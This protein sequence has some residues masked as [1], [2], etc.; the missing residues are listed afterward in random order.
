MT[1]ARLHVLLALLAAQ[2]AAPAEA[3]EV[4][5]V[6]Q[7]RIAPRVVELTIATPAFTTP[8]KV[9]VDLPNGYDSAPRRRWPVAYV[10]AGTMNVR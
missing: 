4:R 2:V 5:I 1:R 9:H 7:E 3:N 10:L 6:K 8:T